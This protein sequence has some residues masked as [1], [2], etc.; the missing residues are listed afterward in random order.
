MK[1]GML[2]LAA[3]AWTS[4]AV[5]A[6]DD[7][8]K[9]MMPGITHGKAEAGHAPGVGKPGD[10]NKV[11]RTVEVLM[12]DD[13]K[14][15]PAKLNVNRSETVRFVVRNAGRIKHEMVIGSVKELKRHAELMRKMP[16]MEHAEPNMVTL[17]P[18]E[19]GELVWQFTKGGTVDFACLQ[20]GHFE[21]GMMG[22]VSVK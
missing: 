9:G 1:T 2:M 3:L 10:P 6:H 20:P 16:E 17:A 22:K 18:G 8:H 15:T 7:A 4:I 21:A 14:F 5:Y 19:T 11:S 13:M 12:R